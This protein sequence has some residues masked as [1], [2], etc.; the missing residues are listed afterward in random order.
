MTDPNW[1]T[2]RMQEPPKTKIH[3]EE[4]TK[5]NKTKKPEQTRQEGTAEGRNR[6]EVKGREGHKFVK[7]TRGGKRQDLRSSSK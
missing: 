1:K 7:I 5:K 6:K 4:V 2:E 3:A